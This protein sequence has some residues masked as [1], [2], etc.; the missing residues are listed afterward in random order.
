MT[1]IMLDLETRGTAPGSIV[2]S[3]GA[4]V[5]DPITGE[6]GATFY[7]NITEESCRAAG[8]T[9]DAATEAWWSKQSAA[10]KAALEDKQQPLPQVLVRFGYWY[11][12]QRGS[13]LWCHGPSFD[14][15][16]LAAAY[17]ALGLP[18]PWSYSDA[19]DTRTVYDL[20]GITP[21]RSKGTHHDAL[22]DAIVQARAVCD[23]YLALGL[24]KPTMTSA[25]AV[26]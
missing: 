1:H 20:A 14:E 25:Q 6:L 18:P 4:T 9:A 11:R 3:I 24:A 26:S 5:F 13:R 21:D 15:A 19:R 2:R 10:A 17:R 16:L 12:D 7:A 8:L 23:G 22:N